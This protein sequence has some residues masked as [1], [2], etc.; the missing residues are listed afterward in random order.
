MGLLGAKKGIPVNDVASYLIA[1]SQGHILIDSTWEETVPM[2]RQ[3]I[4][5]LGLKLTDIKYLLNMQS[6]ADHVA[7]HMR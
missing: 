5:E 7:G 6:H 1:T 2:I 3:S 4:E